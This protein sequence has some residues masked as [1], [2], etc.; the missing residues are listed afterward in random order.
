MVRVVRRLVSL[1]R[2]LR[3]GLL[4]VLWRLMLILRRLL[5]IRCVMV[6]VLRL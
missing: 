2:I 3:L 1:V 6:S 5:V 4:R